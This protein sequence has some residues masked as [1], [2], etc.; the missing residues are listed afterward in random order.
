V[1]CMLS[2]SIYLSSALNIKEKT[3]CGVFLISAE[4]LGGVFSSVEILANFFPIPKCSR[5]LQT[6][7][8]NMPLAYWLNAPAPGKVRRYIS[9]VKPRI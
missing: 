8:T 3:P 5:I 2:I 9:S 1:F 7:A 4:L 6:Y